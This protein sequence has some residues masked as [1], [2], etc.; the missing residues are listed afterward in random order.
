MINAVFTPDAAAVERARAVVA[1]F[2]AAPEAG[3]L[4]IEGEMIDRPHLRRAMRVL[5]RVG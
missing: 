2:A 3:V 5:A 1:A 4:S